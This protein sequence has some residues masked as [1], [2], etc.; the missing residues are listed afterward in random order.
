MTRKEVLVILVK[1]FT[2]V[3]IYAFPCPSYPNILP[4][5][6][7]SLANDIGFYIGFKSKPSAIPKHKCTA[8]CTW[9]CDYFTAY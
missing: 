3:T 6:H 7:F 8:A 1:H 5:L 9:I 4:M 2:P